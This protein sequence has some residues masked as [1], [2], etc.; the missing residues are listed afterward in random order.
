MTAVAGDFA[1]KG[2][3]PKMIPGVNVSNASFEMHPVPAAISGGNSTEHM[4][5]S[6]PRDEVVV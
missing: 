3:V 2:M 1:V 4:M 6:A 5:S